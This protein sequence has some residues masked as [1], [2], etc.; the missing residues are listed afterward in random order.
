MSLDRFEIISNLYNTLQ[1]SL[2]LVKKKEDGK[3]YTIKSVKIDENSE[4]EKELFFNELR[5]LVP[6][7]HKNVIW[8]KEAFYDK[9]T[10]TLNMVIEYVDGGDLSMKIKMAKQKNALFKEIIIWGIFIQILEGI[11]YLHKKYI[12]HR[13]L[14]TS[15]IFL[16]KK[17]AVKIGGLNVGK[18]IEDIGMALTQIGTP[19]FTAPEIWEQKPYD[20]KCD[21]W[22]MGCILYEMTTLNV[23]FLGLNMQ[24]LYQNI[25]YSKYKPIPKM[26]SKELNEIIKIILN[27]NPNERP[28]ANDLLNNEIILEKKKQLNINIDNDDENSNINKTVN[29]IVNDYNNKIRKLDYSHIIYEKVDN[30]SK[31]KKNMKT[32][33]RLNSNINYNQ[34]INDLLN[35]RFNSESNRVSDINTKD[36]KL[37]RS[38]R[39]INNFNNNIAV[40]KGKSFTKSNNIYSLSDFNRII[41]CSIISNSTGKNRRQKNI[42]INKNFD[43]INI[44]ES[45]NINN[46][47]LS[48]Y[49]KEIKTNFLKIDGKVRNESNKEIIKNKILEKRPN[50]T[51]KIL[52]NNNIDKNKININKKEIGINNPFNENML[53]YK[54]KMN[55]NI[56]YN[57]KYKNI[58][59][60]NSPKYI[61]ANE[62][63]NKNKF[64]NYKKLT[65]YKINNPDLNRKRNLLLCNI[66]N[67]NLNLEYNINSS[68]KLMNYNNNI[69][70]LINSTKNINTNN[71]TYN[72]D[73]LLLKN[74]I[75][76]NYYYRNENN[77]SNNL[78]SSINYN[79]D[80]DYTFNNQR[81]NIMKYNLNNVI[82][83]INL[84][85][86]N[87]NLKVS[88]SPNVLRSINSFIGNCKKIDL[89]NL[90]KNIKYKRSNINCLSEK[91][92]QKKYIQNKNNN[93]NND[94]INIQNNNI[95]Y[96]Y[97]TYNNYIK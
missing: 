89:S 30:N 80:I 65:K 52:I 67:S 63:I 7:T 96:N 49:N 62:Y 82:K 17:G 60:E 39:L 28:S 58:N 74:K 66:K 19:Y 36:R 11:N 56:N 72:Q 3:L 97:L 31:E 37:I 14:K 35:N 85:K 64:N 8:Y 26:Y 69:Y 75:I 25:L 29:K 90:Y 13:D 79:N 68:S 44:T 55:D 83:K 76:N 9:I 47:I 48:N 87:N 71:K 40:N 92:S 6:L 73:K 54:Y 86:N 46:N 1:N 20:Y 32:L 2:K 41:D 24:E 45:D 61:K 50:V 38:N 81:K 12:I 94:K 23:P 10:K 18:N 34:K 5:I 43:N 33:I 59:T 88:N 95:N 27:K 78:K 4:K 53:K 51:N 22:S 70:N 91:N 57:L 42:K 84:R 93:N 16:T 21:I 77:I 15:N